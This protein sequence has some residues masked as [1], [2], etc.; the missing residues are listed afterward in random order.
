MA[1]P[2]LPPPSQGLSQVSTTLILEPLTP[3]SFSPFGTAICSPLPRALNNVPTSIP[4]PLHA[5]YQAPPVFANQDSALKTSPISQFTN[6]YPSKP[7]YAPSKPQM[8]MFS[9]FPRNLSS[10]GIDQSTPGKLAFNVSILERHPYTTQTF[11]PL[12]LSADD[13]STVFL[14]IVAP[15]L[16]DHATATTSTDTKVDISNPPDLSRLKAFVARGDQAVTYGAG[17][18]HAPMVVMGQQRVDFV[19]T[20]FANVDTPSNA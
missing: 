19:V 11:S 9:C 18:W 17:T 15:S 20:Q 8:S 5:P 13:K 2:T 10:I 3:S 12:G 4:Q 7:D 16:P 1:P 14:V 6:N